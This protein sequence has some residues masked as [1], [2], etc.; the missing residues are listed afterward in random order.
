[1]HFFIKHW[2]VLGAFVIPYGIRFHSQIPYKDKEDI[3]GCQSMI[4]ITLGHIEHLSVSILNHFLYI[5]LYIDKCI[6]IKS[7][8]IYAIVKHVYALKPRQPGV[9]I[10]T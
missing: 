3:G 5:I 4:S 2:N 6:Y 10:F 7:L 8:N 9:Y 1:M